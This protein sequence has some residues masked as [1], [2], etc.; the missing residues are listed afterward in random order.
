VER[1]HQLRPSSRRAA[2]ENDISVRVLT[3]IDEIDKD[4]WSAL[5]SGDDYYSVGYLEVLHGSNLDCLFRFFVAERAGRIVG[6]CFGYLLHIRMMPGITEKAFS[7]GSPTDTGCFPFLLDERENREHLLRCF[8][9]EM[10]AE[11]R[12]LGADYVWIMDVPEDRLPEVERSSAG[13][14]LVELPMFAQALLPIQWK[15]FDDYLGAMRKRYRVSLRS[16][17]RTV[18]ENGYALEVSRG[19][20]TIALAEQMRRLFME[21]Y[22]RHSEACDQVALPREYFEGVLAR[23]ESVVLLMRKSG[24]LVCFMLLIERESVVE[25]K[26]IGL[27]YAAIGKDQV[28][29]AVVAAG[30]RYAI[31]NGFARLDLGMSNDA[32]KARFGCVFRDIHAYVGPVSRRARFLRWIGVQRLLLPRWGYEIDHTLHRSPYGHIFRA[33]A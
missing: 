32:V 15:S 33:P 13:H 14:G 25:A 17:I 31:E 8:I 20:D 12:R 24:R 30:I 23:P 16:A 3:A 9:E 28:Y 10:L 7:T 27:D 11:A 6:Y 1:A 29:R 2:A 18:T 4:V 21:V 5:C 22:E 26:F 19:R